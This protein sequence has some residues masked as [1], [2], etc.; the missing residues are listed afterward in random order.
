MLVEDFDYYLP[1]SSIA[2]TPIEKRDSSRL[3]VVDKKT[4]EIEHK[5][6]HD[7][8]DFLL[9]GDLLVFNDTKVIPARLFGKRKTGAKIE[10]FLLRRISG[11]EWEVLVKPGRK[12]RIG[13]EIQFGDSMSCRIIDT[14]DFGGR[15]V[16][17]SYEG[18]FE[19]KLAAIGEVPL[20]HYIHEKLEDFDRYQT[21]YARENGSVAAPTAGLHFTEDLL[22]KIRAKGINTAFVTL[23]VGLGTFR[24]VSAE[25]VQDHKMHSE[26][27]TVNKETADLINSVRQKGG[28]VIAVGTTAVRVLESVAAGGSMKEVSGN[29]DIFIYPGYQFKMVDCMITNFHLPKSTLLMLVSAFSS[30]ELMLGVYETA[31][32]ENYRFFSFGDAMFIK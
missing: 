20:P 2:Q 28:R 29:T 19:E 9:P 16:Q 12:A 32:R 17:F 31:V 3:L 8:V 4:G 26:H 21:V 15:I 24:P 7:I 18:I 27:Y 11:D 23:H 6:F 10:V 22:Q 1:L 30:R 14:T 25:A 5:I 13:D